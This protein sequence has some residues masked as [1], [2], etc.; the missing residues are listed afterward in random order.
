MGGGHIFFVVPVNVFSLFC[1]A[2]E[3]LYELGIW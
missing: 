2:S 1:N 3:N